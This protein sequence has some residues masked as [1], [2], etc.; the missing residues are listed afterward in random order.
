MEL[1]AVYGEH[2]VVLEALINCFFVFFPPPLDFPTLNFGVKAVMKTSVL[3]TWDLPQNYKPQGHFK[4]SADNKK[5]SVYSKFN[6]L[7]IS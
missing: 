3:L 2:N 6:V 5:T 4:V 1:A 7:C